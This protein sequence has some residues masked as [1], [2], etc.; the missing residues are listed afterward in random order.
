[1]KLN[2]IN[3]IAAIAI[4]AVATS[5]MAQTP[6]YTIKDL[7]AVNGESEAFAINNYNQVVGW[8]F[9]RDGTRGALLW[10]NN[11]MT[12]LSSVGGTS[13]A[14]AINDQKVIV[15]K[16]GT[17]AVQ[18]IATNQLRDLGTFGGA[19]GTALGLNEY[20]EIAGGAQTRDARW[21]GFSTRWDRTKGLTDLGTLGGVQSMAFDVNN[22]GVY[23]GW[24]YTAGPTHAAL[25]VP[26]QKPQDLGT[27]GGP[28]SEARSISDYFGVTGWSDLTLRHNAPNNKGN[29]KHAFLW[30][31]EKGRKDL[32]DPYSAGKT[33]LKD[34]QGRTYYKLTYR[35][36]E[37]Q[38]TVNVYGVDTFGYGVNDSNT[39][40]GNSRLYLGP[41]PKTIE[42]AFVAI[43]G[44]MYDLNSLLDGN[45]F[46]WNLTHAWGLNDGNV[47]V[48]RGFNYRT[49]SFRAFMATRVR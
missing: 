30:T 32:G 28:Q 48:G 16:R 1:M 19:E 6:Q 34:S 24:A 37:F 47:I 31:P 18:F 27:L 29:V 14:Y 15:G 44:T 17:R 7:G 36:G 8:S 40:C 46:E 43:N 4:A 26:G 22:V 38:R 41:T 23:A 9:L 11:R 21:R 25:F 13:A 33:K 3:R 10:E 42:R 12:I 45:G 20:G 35:D 5:A 2:T 39:V 49:G